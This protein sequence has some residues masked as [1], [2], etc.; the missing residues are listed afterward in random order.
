MLIDKKNLWKRWMPNLKFK[1]WMDSTNAD[2]VKKEMNT[3]QAMKEPIFVTE[4]ILY[5]ITAVSDQ[6]S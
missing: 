1:S 2:I 3:G 6:G 5:S 4:E